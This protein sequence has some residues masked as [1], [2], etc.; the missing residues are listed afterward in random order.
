MIGAHDVFETYLRTF[1]SLMKADM[2]TLFIPASPGRTVDAELVHVGAPPPVP[3]LATVGDAVRFASR[4]RVADATR[5]TPPPLLFPSSLPE[6]RLL[7]LQSAEVVLDRIDS[8]RTSTRRRKSDREPEEPV[9]WLGLRFASSDKGLARL[10]DPTQRSEASGPDRLVAEIG[11]LLTVLGG[12]LTRYHRRV[13]SVVYDTVSGLPGRTELQSHLGEELARAR[14]GRSSLTLM[15]INPDD[16]VAVN[17]NFGPTAGDRVIREIAERLR[18]VARKG[19]FIARYGGAIFACVLAG[20]DAGTADELGERFREGLTREPFLDGALRLGFSLGIASFDPAVAEPPDTLE[21]VRR[22]DQALSAAK[23]GGGNL[24]SSWGGRTEVEEAAALVRLSGLF[25]GN[26]AKDYRNMVLLWNALG[27]IASTADLDRLAGGVLRTLFAAVKPDRL[28]LFVERGSGSLEPTVGLE[29]SGGR[30]HLPRELATPRLDRAVLSLVEEAHRQ[31]MSQRSLVG[32]EDRTAG[33]SAGRAVY[34]LPMMLGRESCGCLVFEGTP[35]RLDLD[36]SDMIF[37]EGLAAQLALS[38]DRA[39]L[40]EQER[41]REEDERRRLKAELNELRSAM[42]QA[43]LVFHSAQMES[44]L[45]TVRRVAATEATVLITGESGTGK[46]LVARTLHELSPRR[47]GPMVVLDCAAIPVSLIESELFG[48]ERGAYTGA[49]QR[50]EG[51]LEQA[52]GGTLLLDEISELPLEV[53]S[54]LLRFVQEKELTRVGGTSS[55]R[56]DARVVAATN[57]NL[58]REVAAGRFR[59]DLYHR[60]NVVQL[61]VPPLRERPEDILHIARHYLETFSL[62]Y[63]KN[64]QR[65]S[66][67]AERVLLEHEWPGNVR[68]LLNRMMG[69]VILCEGETI[70]VGH[71]APLGRAEDDADTR[72]LAS[73]A[74]TP[75]SVGVGQD[76][77]QSL[78]DALGREV[79]LAIA[80]GAAVARPI[81]RWLADDLVLEAHAASFGVVARAAEL[82]GAPYSTFSRRFNRAEAQAAAGAAPRSESWRAVRQAIAT[83]LDGGSVEDRLLEA[84]ERLLLEVIVA[85]VPDDPGVGSALL[86]VSLPTFRRRLD[87]LGSSD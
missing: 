63:Q 12:A 71:L 73:V 31:G 32:E 29:R 22:A 48:H 25:T 55:R 43:R 56:L 78:R 75:P 4:A 14:L 60:L 77:W 19:D 11:P 68:E 82:V 28:V 80:E 39:R 3:E 1:Q 76:P 79:E 40:A 20:T 50:A 2:V 85:C 53:Q 10:L 61:T 5:S 33:A 21:L 58:E 18:A 26:M 9:A 64:I 69:A 8:D 45:T 35:E 87:R 66:P 52:N 13:T 30:G 34:V 74:S 24:V 6:G 36:T 47:G 70:E 49:Q 16:F 23:R 37:L 15:L 17:E 57:R 51:R 54:R 67:E 83:L 42:Q 72:R 38:L 84:S 65:L 86:G 62:N 44:L 59:E 27:V 81:G 7:A 41:L 46:E